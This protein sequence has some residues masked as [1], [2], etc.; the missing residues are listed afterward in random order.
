MDTKRTL[1]FALGALILALLLKSHAQSKSEESE[2]AIWGFVYKKG[3]NPD[4]EGG[5]DVI[6]DENISQGNVDKG[7]EVVPNVVP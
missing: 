3:Q 5:V 6:N 1:R 2:Y 4:L 7:K